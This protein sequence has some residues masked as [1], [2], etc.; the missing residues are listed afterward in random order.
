LPEGILILEP[1]AP[2]EA[3]D[4]ECLVFKHV[5]VNLRRLNAARVVRLHAVDQIAGFVM[6]CRGN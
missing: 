1:A 5:P 6:I 3:A 4:F 2:L